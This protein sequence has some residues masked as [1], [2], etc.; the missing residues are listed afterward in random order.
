MAL[1]DERGRVLGRINLIDLGVALA[2]LAIVASIVVGYALFRLPA[3]PVIQKVE[4]ATFVAGPDLRLHLRGRNFLPFMRVFIQRTGESARAIHELDPRRPADQYTLVNSLQGQFL[5]ES[6]EVA[7]FKLPPDV[8]PGTYDLAFYNET[9]QM[10]VKE[11][12]FTVTAPPAPPPPPPAPTAT[13]RVYGAFTGLD[14]AAADGIKAAGH[15]TSNT[16]GEIAETINVENAQNDVSRVRIGG[17]GVVP[18]TVADKLQVPAL[19]RV[20]CSIVNNECRVGGTVLGTEAAL[21][22]TAGKR[23]YAFA[24]IDVSADTAGATREADAT[25]RFV[26]RPETV[27]LIAAGDLDN[28]L[29]REHSP[30]LAR[31]ESVGQKRQATSHTGFTLNDVGQQTFNTDEPVVLVDA[32]VRVPLVQVEAAWFYKGQPIKAGGALVFETPSYAVRGWIL[33]V[34]FAGDARTPARGR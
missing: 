2:G 23:S 31:I 25:V 34:S 24:V 1:I 20:R 32:V 9:Q 19:L 3:R 12:A 8:G 30:R 11:A 18:A 17:A 33:D 10:A 4:P 7:E 28:R 22:L 27:K 21:T 15:F 13:V 14:R 16:P 26:A 6:P 29:S 5:V